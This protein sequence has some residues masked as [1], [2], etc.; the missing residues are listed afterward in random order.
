MPS[1]AQ[2]LPLL[3]KDYEAEQHT[4]SFRMVCGCISGQ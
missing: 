3:G 4:L 2:L 1:V